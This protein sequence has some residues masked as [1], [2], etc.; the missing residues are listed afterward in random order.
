MASKYAKTRIENKMMTLLEVSEEY[1]IPLRTIL[2]RYNRGI[3]GEKLLDSYRKEIIKMEINGV[4]MTIKEIAE[5]AGIS[6][7]NIFYRIKQGY[8][9]E[10]LLA[11]SL[12]EVKKKQKV[13]EADDRRVTKEQLRLIAEAEARHEQ[14]I[15]DKKRAEQRAREKERLAMIAKHRVRSKW[16]VYLEENCIFPKVKRG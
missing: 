12:V 1:N 7:R 6:E 13:S 4:M 3:R 8:E 16:L 9:G 2:E 10:D 14:M 15:R 11:K 5:K